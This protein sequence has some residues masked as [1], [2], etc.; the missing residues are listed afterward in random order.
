MAS[1]KIDRHRHILRTVAQKRRVSLADLESMLNASRI[2]VQRDL[3][4]LESRSLIKRFHGGAMAPDYAGNLY[5]HSLRKSLN[6]GI[7]RRVASKAARLIAASFHIGMD[8]SSTVYYMAECILPPDVSVL[9]LGVDTFSKL[10]EQT[11]LELV[12]AG[13][14][15]NRSTGTLCGAEAVD[16]IRKFHLDAVFISAESF[17][18]EFGFIDPCPDEIM[19]KRALIESSEKTVILLD[20]SKISQNAGL[21]LC[22]EKEVSHLVT[23]NPDHRE[24]K[25][26]FKRRL[27]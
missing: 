20:S 12:L 8:A 2:T 14:R 22:T 1:F 13:G 25:R 10:S 4:E 17:V 16:V 6:V 23:D 11:G 27:V 15:L 19:V 9:T 21:R 3:L 26:I 18:P 24:L 5:D 7:K